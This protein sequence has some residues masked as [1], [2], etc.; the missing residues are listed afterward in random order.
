MENSPVPLQL[1]TKARH[2]YSCI[3]LECDVVGLCRD[4]A[5]V[6]SVPGRRGQDCVVMGDSR[7][8]SVRSGELRWRHLADVAEEKDLGT[9]SGLGGP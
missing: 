9:S 1:I 6:Q 4:S 3:C 7:G 2:G 5:A 8:Q